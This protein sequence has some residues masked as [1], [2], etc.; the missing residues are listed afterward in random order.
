M[1][2]GKLN[3]RSYAD[4]LDPV[5]SEITGES[6]TR[7]DQAEACNI[8]VIYAKTQRG[9]IVLARDVMPTFDDFS[10]EL[11]YDR[12]LEA[13][14]EAEEAFLELPATER[15]K[16][17]HDPAKYYEGVYKDASSKLEEVQKRERQEQEDKAKQDAIR[18]AEKLL[19][20]QPPNT[21]K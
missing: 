17:G 4:P 9:E 1:R 16:Y 8:N 11:T 20:S 7:Q 19:S 18:E 13:I 5:K 6:M 10:N 15:A 12:M 2:S 3:P 21:D 14:S